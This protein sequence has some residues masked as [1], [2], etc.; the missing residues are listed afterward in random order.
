MK[1]NLFR[2][3]A[4]LFALSATT[5]PASAANPVTHGKLEYDAPAANW[6][7]ALP[8][9]NGRLGAMVFGGPAA[10][11]LQ[12][13]EETIWAGKPN[14]A[15]MPETACTIPEVRRLIFEGKYTEAQQLA[16][17]KIMPP[18]RD[19]Y[20]SGMPYQTFGDLY[21]SFPEHADYTDYHREL[22]LDSARTT[23]TYKVGGTTFRREVFASLADPVI[24][25][26]L[27]ASEKGRIRFTAHYATPQPDVT[28]AAA[29]NELV[30]NGTTG[31]HE[32]VRGG[33][34]FEGRTH[35][36]AEGGR[37]F[38]KDGSL[39][40]LD[41]NA[42]TL[43][44]AIATGF[45][46]YTDISGAPTERTKAHLTQ[47]LTKPYRQ[48]VAEHTRRFK[49]QMDRVR[50]YLGEPKSRE[51]TDR[52]IERFAETNDAQLV[53]TYFQ[54]GRYLLI[55]SSQPGTQAATLQ[56]LWND[57]LFPSWDSKYTCNINLEM[58]YWPSE[59]CN[60]S[61]LNEPLFRLIDE[62]SRTG[63]ITA[64]K[65]YDADGW[66]LHHNTDLWR[67]T[68]PV[69]RASA[70]LWASGG[71][72]LCRHLWEHY[73][74][75]GDLE[76]LRRVYPT[77]REAAR[78]FDC[79]TVHEPEHGWLVACPSSSPENTPSGKRSTLYG[80]CTMDN[81]LIGDLWYTVSQA[82]RLLDTDRDYAARLENRMKELP[83]LQIGRWGQ[84]QEW[85]YDWDS[86]DDKHR[87]VSHLYGLFPGNRISA[88]RTPE[89]FDA[90]RTSLIA[91]GDPSTGWSMGWKVCLWARLLDGDHAYKLI[92]DQ[93][94]IVREKKRGGTYPNLFD[95]HPPFQI[96]GNFGC[97]AGIV[98]MLMQSHDGFIH[99][100]PALPSVW[101]Q[102][103]RIDGIRARGG[104]ELSLA[105]K[106][107][108]ITEVRITSHNGGNCR[109]RSQTPL[110]GAG[111]KRA[112]GANP[113]PLYALPETDRP[114]IHAE[115]RPKP[116]APAAGYLYDLPT[117]A[118][119]TYTLKSR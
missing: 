21:L 47:A 105:W 66:V 63:T 109:L 14:A 34:S 56:G 10:E 61:E 45:N 91:R 24:V 11:R 68:T 93:L 3:G 75:T 83:P 22:S 101:A 2:A 99:L 80:G 55:C 58:N 118:G 110:V 20:N 26:R 54:F 64:R 8:V 85:M 88:F 30:L 100:L 70:G 12:L 67:I 87:H 5:L 82:A 27:T 65:L 98:E 46:D 103:G 23:T 31:S 76:F 50:L 18:H 41:A 89:L 102:E 106:A 32:G 90:A 84:L 39:T 78:F 59:S 77:M 16:D 49:E 97:T 53:A 57:K 60:L 117:R 79:T 44:I 74:Y 104:F 116:V 13:N 4:M 7:E 52:R 73:L 29:G 48:A 108:R 92:T 25:V 9:G 28:V 15:H 111:L 17:R 86:P 107:G 42:A 36:V 6:N 113:N 71:A 115:A 94:S 96:D 37:I 119:E 40:V 112:K 95:A 43:Y 114:L 81:L 51:S 19:G 69:D 38:A 1:S 62:V 33:V 72:W 35:I